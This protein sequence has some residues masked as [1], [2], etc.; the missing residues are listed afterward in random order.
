M[1][2]PGGSA[3]F[4]A[5]AWTIQPSGTRFDPPI[6]VRIPN[7]RNLKPGETSQ[8]Y[9]WDH[10]LAA[11]VPMGQ[12]TVSEDGALLVIDVGSGVSKAGWGGAPPTPPSPPNCGASPKPTERECNQECK[13]LKSF[14]G[15]CPNGTCNFSATLNSKEFSCCSGNKFDKNS[16]CCVQSGT[17]NKGYLYKKDMKFSDPR[18]NSYGVPRVALGMGPN[19]Q[20]PGPPELDFPGQLVET[21]TR[22][23][24]GISVTHYVDGCSAPRELWGLFP[25]GLFV[26]KKDESTYAN[27][28]PLA[29]YFYAACREHDFC[30]QTCGAEQGACDRALKTDIESL[31]EAND[32]TLDLEGVGSGRFDPPPV[33]NSPGACYGPAGAIIPCNDLLRKTLRDECRISAFRLIGGLVVGGMFA[34]NDRQNQMCMPCARE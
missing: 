14:G 30:Y 3:T 9:Q 22:M 31:C 26:N 28:S 19:N 33:E 27:A 29:P 2:P 24:N 11:F 6:E 10:D 5:P 25:I 1:V 18:Q 20:F 12:A 16:E 15:R 21:P 17:L 34:W 8:I 32:P 4:M 7:S 13:V 23:T